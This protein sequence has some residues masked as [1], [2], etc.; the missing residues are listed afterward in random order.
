MK[1]KFV[2]RLGAAVLLT[3]SI[4][5]LA[6]PNFSTTVGALSPKAKVVGS[7]PIAQLPRPPRA[8]GFRVKSRHLLYVALPGSGERPIDPA[9]DGIVVLNADN[10]YA[11]V[12][13]IHV[14]N[15]VASMGPETIEGV[16][17]DP[18]TNMI[19]LA[20][21]G[22]LGAVDLATDKLVWSTTLGGRCCERPQVTGDGKT[23]SLARAIRIT[24]SSW[25]PEPASSKPSFMRRAA[26][27][28][29]I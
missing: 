14:W 15:Y 28:P 20:A 21:S 22:R 18:A 16:A 19:Y 5:A 29:T 24:G 13:R 9:G 27:A 10:N 8:V 25:T 23:T 2:A 26:R 4:A 17:A 1:S 11:F 3:G 6:Q 12:K 7:G